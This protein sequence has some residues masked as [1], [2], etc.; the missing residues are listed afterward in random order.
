MA[1]DAVRRLLDFG[2]ANEIDSLLL[3]R[4]GRLV[5][6]AYY[7]PY[8]SGVKHVVN[9]ATKAVVGTL[10]G[11][12]VQDGLLK[13][14]NLPMLAFLGDK[15]SAGL[16]ADKQAITVQHLLNMTSGLDWKEPLDGPPESMLQM[17][18]SPDWLSFVLGRPMAQ[19]PG[20]NFN[21]NSGNS[22]LLSGVLTKLS[23][24]SAADFARQR[25]FEPLGITD[26]LWRQDPQGLTTGGFGLSMHPR[27]M[28]K[29]GYLYLHKGVWRGRQLLPS[30]WTDIVA[31]AP[32]DMHQSYAPS[33]RYAN[34]WWVFPQRDVYMAVG[35]HRQ[36][37]VVLPKF[38]MVAV[39]TGKS[40]YSFD[41]L[42][43]LLEASASSPVPLP[44]NAMARA[45][46]AK[47]VLELATEQPSVVGPPPELASRISGQ[48][49]RFDANPLGLQSMVLDLRSATP[50]Y[51]LRFQGAGATAGAQRLVAPIGLDGRLRTTDSATGRTLATK[52]N[53]V[54]GHTLAMVLHAIGEGEVTHYTLRFG[55][56]TVDISVRHNSGFTAELRGVTVP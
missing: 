37:I 56:G 20:A 1:S 41:L 9:S 51:E 3:V 7:A 11:V 45:V 31:R 26:T 53:W 39:L 19:A 40:H 4:H 15:T 27:D 44:E 52:A 18:R 17:R 34:G 49:Y 43:G 5:V 32:V 14:T 6:D 28:A 22:Q 23:G 16:V 50:S 8:R 24:R 30:N 42:L 35:Y 33:L 13:N 47:R 29:I 10:I 46:L 38:D 48:I 2:A 55:D 36:L 25:L 21:Y 54:D 12:A